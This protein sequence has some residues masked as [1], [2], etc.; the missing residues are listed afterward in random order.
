MASELGRHQAELA[1][2]ELAPNTL[3]RTWLFLERG[4]ASLVDEAGGAGTAGD[5]QMRIVEA[6]EA[7][8]ARLAQEVHDGPGPGAVERDLPGR[9]HRARPR[10]DPRLADDGAAASCASCSAASWA[11]CGLHQ[12]APAAGARR[13]GP[14]RAPSWRRSSTCNALTGCRIATELAAP[15]TD[16]D[17]RQQTVALRVVQEAL[18]NV[19]KH[20]AAS[21]VP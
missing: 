18:Q 21:H 13:A 2:L 16:L 3:E 9:V 11:T 4:D 10:P 12:P 5:I 17:D 6:Q 8:R 7:E 1:R 19:R 20:A 14:G 15:S